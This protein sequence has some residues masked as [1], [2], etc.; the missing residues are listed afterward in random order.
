MNQTAAQFIRQH[1]GCKLTAYADTGGV[2]TCGWGA[3][4]PDIHPGTTWTQAQADARLEQD[5]ERFERAVDELVKVP[6]TDNQRAAL[7]SFAFNLG[8]HAL[9]GSTLLRKL[10]AGD[11]VG[12][13]AEFQKWDRAGGKEVPGLLKRRQEESAIFLAG[14]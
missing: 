5:V 9:A 1:E 11:M 13:A 2:F 8:A 7:T 4:G 6:I 14:S 10:N 12:A 3:T